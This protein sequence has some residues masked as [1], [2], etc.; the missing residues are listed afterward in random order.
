MSR[1]PIFLAIIT[2][3]IVSM[4]CSFTINLPETRLRTGDTVT[5]NIN[6][7]LFDDPEKTAE[8]EII[9]G[10]GELKLVPGAENSLVL[11]T[12]TYNVSDF[13][14]EITRSDNKVQ[15][16]QGQTEGFSTLN[17]GVRNEWD[18]A[19]GKSPMN[20]SITA[21]AYR[22]EIDLG[23][24]SLL[25]LIVKE[26]ASDTE[27]DFSSP[28]LVEMKTFIYST[29]A[30]SAKLM[31]LANA[32]FERM[33]FKGGVGSYKLDLSGELRKNIIVEVDAGLS[34]LVIAVPR[35]VPTQVTVEGSL[36]NINTSGDWQR[37]ENAYVLTGNGHTITM[38]IKMGAG[39]LELVH[40]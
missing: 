33:E 10:A 22:G 8:L 14:P 12:A 37:A 21:G 16:K 20:L 28:N 29:G 25:E 5:D 17:P 30:S 40:P 6:V 39:N 13:K 1:K 7:Q 32:N 11:G 34:N 23:G 36:T 31:N 19:L 4:A 35:D 9:F 38:E 18:L 2:V 24:L 15:V 26:G 27:W 3:A